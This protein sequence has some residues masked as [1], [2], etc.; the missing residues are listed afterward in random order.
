MRKGSP[1]YSL[2]MALEKALKIWEGKFTHPSH[3]SEA[4]QHV[5]HVVEGGNTG[6]QL[7]SHHSQPSLDGSGTQTSRT[8]LSLGESLEHPPLGSTLNGGISS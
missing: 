6:S 8:G 7:P 1:S 4:G 5:L 3:S 2:V